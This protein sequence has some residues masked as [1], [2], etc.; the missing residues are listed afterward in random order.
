MFVN[1]C[2][3][4]ECQQSTNIYLAEN[5]AKKWEITREQQDQ[6]AVSSQQKAAQGQKENIFQAEIIPVSVNT[7]KGMLFWIC[8]NFFN[9]VFKIEHIQ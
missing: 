7:R 3:I 9:Y 6:F 1:K 5:V 8:V 2:K 4:Q